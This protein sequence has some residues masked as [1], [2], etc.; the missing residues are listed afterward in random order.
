MVEFQTQ[1]TPA[2]LTALFAAIKRGAPARTG[3]EGERKDWYEHYQIEDLGY[4]IG[5]GFHVPT[6]TLLPLAKITES[7]FFSRWRNKARGVT[8]RTGVRAAE[9]AHLLI[10]LEQLGLNADPEPLVAQLLPEIK[11]LPHL[12]PSELNVLWFA[13]ERHKFKPR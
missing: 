8:G 11:Q 12:S 9:M 10:F 3:V 7:T 6:E 2:F 13:N 5:L 4:E 1:L